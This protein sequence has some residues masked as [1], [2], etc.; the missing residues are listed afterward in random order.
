[1]GRST[2][3]HVWHDVVSASQAPP[4]QAARNVAQVFLGTNLKCASCHDSFVNHWRLKEA[5]SLAAVFA[6][7]P[8]EINRCDKPTGKT[9]EAACVFPELGRIDPATPK[10]DRQRQLADI[11]TKQDNGRLARTMVNR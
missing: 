11:L 5:Y 4:V 9:A 2:K 1:A 3:W 7:G 10:P 6:D 8:V